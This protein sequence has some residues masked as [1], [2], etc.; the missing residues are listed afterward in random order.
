VRRIF[1]KR[2]RKKTKEK[3][4]RASACFSFP[5]HTFKTGYPESKRHTR[6]WFENWLARSGLPLPKWLQF[7][8]QKVMEEKIGSQTK[9]RPE[10]K[11]KKNKTRKKHRREAKQK[12]K[13]NRDRKSTKQ[14]PET[15]EQRMLASQTEQ[16]NESQTKQTRADCDYEF[17]DAI[18]KLERYT[19]EETQDLPQGLEALHRDRLCP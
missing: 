2:R 17:L 7:S 15:S 14:R 18:A 3:T 6:P 10:I 11:R 1:S 16:E 8:G 9:G 12:V 4:E 13:R 19:A 5:E